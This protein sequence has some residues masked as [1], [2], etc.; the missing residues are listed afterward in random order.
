MQLPARVDSVEALEDLLSLPSQALIDDLSTL[1]GDLMI[2]GVGG[3]MGPTLARLA[4]RALPGRRVVGVARFSDDSVRERLQHWD[5]ET[6]T[7]D[8]L[9]RDALQALPRVRNIVFAAGHKFGASGNPALTWAMNTWLPG[10]VAQTFSDSRIVA[11]STGN[12]Y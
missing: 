12:V 4:K 7:A 10:M 8:L 6:L 3:K 5:I 1:D 2:L 11:F 9:D